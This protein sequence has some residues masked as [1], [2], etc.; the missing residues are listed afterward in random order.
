[1]RDRKAMES[2][3]GPWGLYSWVRGG[4]S[5]AGKGQQWG[6]REGG[7]GS[8]YG[9]TAVGTMDGPS[10]DRPFAPDDPGWDKRGYYYLRLVSLWRTGRPDVQVVFCRWELTSQLD[11]DYCQHGKARCG[12]EGR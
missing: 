7:L 3:A 6:K 11:R 10:E 12:A 4:S 8:C 2:I 1:M 9:P 5:L